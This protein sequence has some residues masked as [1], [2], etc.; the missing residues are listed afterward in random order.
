MTERSSN[1]IIMEHNGVATV[2]TRPDLEIDLE[3][4]EEFAQAVAGVVGNAACSAAVIDLSQ[5]SFM[6][7]TSL[8]VLLQA[9]QDMRTHERALVLDIA[10]YRTSTIR[11]LFDVAGV[12]DL[13]FVVDVPPIPGVFLDQ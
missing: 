13:F 11:R 1:F 3:R 12:N 8:S 5:A 4:R 6:D 7:C 9:R 10:G 2:G